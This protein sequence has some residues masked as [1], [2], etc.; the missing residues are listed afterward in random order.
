MYTLGK[1]LCYIIVVTLCV[2]L[3]SPALAQE[4]PFSFGVMPQRTRSLRHN[5]GILFSTISARRVVSPYSSNRTR[6]PR[7]RSDDQDGEF[8]YSNYLF[9]P[10]NESAGYTVIARR[11]SRHQR[12]DRRPGQLADPFSGGVAG[13]R[14]WLSA[15]RRFCGLP[16][17]FGYVIAG[18][19]SRAGGHSCRSRRHYGPTESRA[20]GGGWRQFPGHARLRQT[21][22]D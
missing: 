5:T 14:S 10:W 19:D 18:R 6:H 12:R 1:R 11:G 4:T 20:R 3:V 7:T 17:D 21:R 16:R 13:P 8:A 9:S 15:P 22:E 2:G